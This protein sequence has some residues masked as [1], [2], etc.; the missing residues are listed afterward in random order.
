MAAAA[1]ALD[2]QQPA[3]YHRPFPVQWYSSNCYSNSQYYAIFCFG[4]IDFFGALLDSHS[5]WGDLPCCS[6][7]LNSV[8]TFA[9]F[10]SFFLTAFALGVIP[11][12]SAPRQE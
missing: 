8:V 5:Y 1:A 3:Q 6:T 10:E 9:R 11:R 7:G 4:V 2:H 12:K